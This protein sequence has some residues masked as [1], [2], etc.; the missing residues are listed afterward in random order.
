MTSTPPGE[1]DSPP[2]SRYRHPRLQRGTL[3]AGLPGTPATVL[4]RE[5][6]R[7]PL[8]RR[9]RR[10]RFHRRHAGR[11]NATLTA[12]RGRSRRR[13]PGAEGPRDARSSGRGARAT[14]ISAPTWTLTSRRTSTASQTC[15]ALSGMAT[16]SRQAPASSAARRRLAPSNASS[17]PA[18][19]T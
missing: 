10:Q 7:L 17:C 8:A 3:P 6:D 4:P 11:G 14:P 15:L 16:M 18:P 19:T 2:L 5:P 1:P 9:H 12:I 13:S